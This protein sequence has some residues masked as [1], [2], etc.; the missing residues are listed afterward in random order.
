MNLNRL[1]TFIVLAEERSFSQTAQK[2]KISQP[3]IT[4]Q[5]KALE[6]EAGFPL[7]NRE[8]M[9]LTTSGAILFN[10]GQKLLQDWEVIYNKAALSHAGEQ[11]SLHVGASSIPG[12]YLLP[13]ALSLLEDSAYPTDLCITLDSS[14]KMIEQLRHFELDLAFTGSKPDDNRLVS[15]EIAQDQLVLVGTPE[16]SAIHS[17]DDLM[18]ERFISYREGSGT[19]RATKKAITDFGGSF[20]DLPVIAVVPNTAGALALAASGIGITAV[21]SF[22][23]DTVMT[24]HVKILCE[25]PTDRS[26]YAVR[27][28]NSQHPH[29]DALIQAMIQSATR[30]M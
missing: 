14:A 15:T 7:L 26:F 12:T 11:G 8:T 10:E 22:A 27:H 2:L 4:K 9:T 13:Q 6:K 18:N 16:K 5:I 29:T 30:Q 21:S 17:A 24:Q 23:L 3:A 1:H 25:L 19:L 20:D 28:A